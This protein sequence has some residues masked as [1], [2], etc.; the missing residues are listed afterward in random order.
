MKIEYSSRFAKDLRNI[1]DASVKA[2]IAEVLAI[3]K[4]A[5]R[6]QEIPDIKKMGGAKNAFRAKAGEFR[7]GFYFNHDTISL[8]RCVNRKD[9]YRSFP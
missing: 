6:L 9:I 1:A 4:S 5:S 3:M 2:E 8:A 7:I